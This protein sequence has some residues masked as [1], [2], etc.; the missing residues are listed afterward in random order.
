MP[1]AP[2]VVV[3]GQRNTALASLAGAMRHHGATAS[4]IRAALLQHNSEVCRPPL[5]DDEVESVAV[6]IGK[7]EPDALA[8]DEVLATPTPIDWA[9]FA[10]ADHKVADWLAEP[11]L[12]RGKLTMIY[13]TGGAGKSLLGL[14]LGAKLALGQAVINRPD[15]EPLSVVYI[16]GEMTESD[17]ADRLRSM[18]INAVELANLH[19]YLL[20][21]LPPL[22]T[23]E[24]GAALLALC[25]KH[26]ADICII[27]PL[28]YMIEGDENESG[29]IKN[30]GRYTTQP[31]KASGVTLLLMD[32]AGKDKRQGPRGASAKQNIADV[33]W[34][35]T[36]RG[37]GVRLNSKLPAGKRRQGW[38]PERVDLVRTVGPL[39][40][41]HVETDHDIKI[42]QVMGELDT[43]G[44]P[45][46][47][48]N[49]KAGKLY[50]DAGFSATQSLI[51]EAQRQ[52]R[53][54]RED[55]DDEPD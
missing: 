29:P 2:L 30:M 36:T 50:R 49:H 19:Y 34:K 24:G 39:A 18:D 7:Y 27:D 5:D 23:A 12:P 6:S 10:A 55:D 42:E 4:A 13:S 21:A 52:R 53:E 1:D 3:K 28:V 46:E 22:D 9:V 15:G 31:L 44:V 25:R 41:V 26:K 54:P 32:H 48:G 8:R 11:V 17:L 37:D 38:I 14:E 40:H 47:C 45:L 16:D 43:L 51:A 20:Q 35:M 33:I